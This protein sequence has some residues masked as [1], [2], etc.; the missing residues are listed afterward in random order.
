[1]LLGLMLF[2]CI[3]SSPVEEVA[4]VEEK[5]PHTAERVTDEDLE[6]S[7]WLLGGYR[8]YGNRGYGG[9]G[10]HHHYHRPYYGGYG[11]YGG[12]RGYRGYGGFGHYG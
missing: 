2:Q 3:M 8:G 1:M 12:Y 9:Y 11:A 6:T 10:H 5:V 4:A 7:P